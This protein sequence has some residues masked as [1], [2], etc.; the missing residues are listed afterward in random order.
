MPT[1]YAIWAPS[2]LASCP[3]LK[4]LIVR[5]RWVDAEEF[6]RV[7][8]VVDLQ[9]EELDCPFNNIFD[10]ARELANPRTSL[11]KSLKHLSYR[12]YA[13]WRGMKIA[14]DVVMSMLAVNHT[15]EY[16]NV[17]VPSDAHVDHQ[18][19]ESFRAFHN[20]VLPVMS[21]PLPLACRIAFIGVFPS[22]SCACQVC[23][24]M[25][26]RTETVPSQT[27]RLQSVLAEFPKNRRMLSLIFDFAAPCARRRV[28]LGRYG[29]SLG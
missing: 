25:R 22:S 6:L 3:S 11:A 26:A 21:E 28:Y 24:S 18:A 2:M 14:L 19:A 8:R 4:T 16:L 10:S 17:T 9:L 15:L 29:D 23:A 5:G 27:S 12:F 20:Q 1:A 7:Y 13:N